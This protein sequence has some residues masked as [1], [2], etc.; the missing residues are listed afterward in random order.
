MPIEDFN[1]LI[2]DL[3]GSDLRQAREEL[4]LSQTQLGDLLGVDKKTIGRWET[5][6]TPIHMAGAVCLAMKYL[7]LHRHLTK[8]VLPNMEA[9][10]AERNAGL[11]A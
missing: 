3:R 11:I 6:A 9:D 2:L 1:D 4:G 7:D 5:Y 10:M 8:E